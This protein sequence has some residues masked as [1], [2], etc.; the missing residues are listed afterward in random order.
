[1]QDKKTC[2]RLK[3]D[4]G[5]GYN[6][7]DIKYGAGTS[8]HKSLG[9]AW[10]DWYG[11]YFYGNGTAANGGG[12]STDAPF[13]RLMV[14]FEDLIFFPYET[15]K[16]ICECAGGILGHRQDDKDVPDDGTFHYVVRSAKAGFG[17][18]PASQRNGLID[19]WQR[20]GSSDPKNAYSREDVDVAE[21]VLDSLIMSTFGYA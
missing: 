3:T 1:M 18:G 17:H 13:P 14:R 20:Y 15:T 5:E 12:K 11:M 8:H 9:H 6:P 7:V 2:P 19:S 16:Q 10:S 4:D 21:D